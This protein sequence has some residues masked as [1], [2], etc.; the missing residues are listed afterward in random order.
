[1][2]LKAGFSIGGVEGTTF[3]VNFSLGVRLM[4]LPSVK[5]FKEQ[6]KISSER[7]FLLRK[8]FDFSTKEIPTCI[9]V[10]MKE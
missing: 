8:V 5:P 3:S 2:P 4:I 7:C 10:H 9:S 6:E 1:M